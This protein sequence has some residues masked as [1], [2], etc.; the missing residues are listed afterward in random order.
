MKLAFMDYPLHWPK[1]YSAPLQGNYRC[2]MA[3]FQVD[4]QVD[5]E[6]SGQGEHL[7]VLVR[8][9]GANTEWVARQLANVAGIAAKNVGFAGL[10][11]RHAITTQWFS[12]QLPGQADPDFSAL[13][14][15]IE[16]L[17]QQRH[18]RKLKRGALT[19]NHFRL[20]LREVSG[21]LKAAEAVWQQIGEHGIPNYF[22]EQRFGNHGANL[23]KAEHWFSGKFRPKQRHHRGLYLSSARSWLFNQ[24]LA[25]RIEQGNWQQALAGDVFVLDG[26]HGWFVDDGS[27]DLQARLDEGDIHVSGMMWGRGRL[28][29][30]GQAAELEQSVA[31]EYPLFCEGLERNGLK[32]ER[33]TLRVR[34]QTTGFE[35][36]ADGSLQ[37]QFFLPAGAYA[38]SVLAQLGNFSSAV[39]GVEGE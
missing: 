15:D 2:S 1:A 11:D 36:L 10:K 29:T 13:P 12:L 21:D 20:V 33:R 34:V 4:E 30:V 26:G 19:G 18:D 8:K 16:V 9:T 5:I 28:A 17:E 38:T 24:V 7:W 25:K 14:A 23:Q 37:L 39:T 35:L 31:A 27:D 6:R 32:Q 22:G 3:D